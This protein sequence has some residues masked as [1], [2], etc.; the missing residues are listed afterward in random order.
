MTT[1]QTLDKTVLNS[2]HN[3]IK[4]QNIKINVSDMNLLKPQNITVL[5]N[6]SQEDEN[7]LF[8]YQILVFIFIFSFLLSVPFLI[9]CFS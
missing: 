7:Y 3:L 1:N 6:M 8:I 4:F 2:S 9:I 5:E